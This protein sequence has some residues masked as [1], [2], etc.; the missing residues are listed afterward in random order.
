MCRQT[1][2]ASHRQRGVTLVELV[3][4]IVIISIAVTG[5]LMAYVTMVSRSADPLIDVQA[6]AIAEAYMDEILSKP[7]AGT[8]GGCAT[9]ASCYI[10]GDYASLP[11][12]PP[13]DQSGTA[14]PA[15]AAY[16][17]TV[18]IGG[19]DLGIGATAIWVTVSHGSGRS[20]TLRSHKVGF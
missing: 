17:V 2:P 11:P 1:E 4:A 16:T 15:L 13:A 12:G 9:R 14:I 19:P 3:L 18:T 5:V 10:V 7:V 6:T 8:S 20:V